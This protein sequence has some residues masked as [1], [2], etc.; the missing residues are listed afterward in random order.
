MAATERVESTI[1]K[2][3]IVMSDGRAINRSKINAIA[4][5]LIE[6]WE[7]FQIFLGIVFVMR[8]TRNLGRNQT[9]CQN[10]IIIFINCACFIRACF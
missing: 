1:F 2:H 5:T 4:E 9:N 3:Y 6:Q 7:F 10:V 8:V